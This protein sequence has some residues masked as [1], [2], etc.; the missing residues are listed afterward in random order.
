MVWNPTLA[1]RQLIALPAVRREPDVR[2][3]MFAAMAAYLILPVIVNPFWLSI[4]DQAGI[5]A[6]AAL[7]LNLLTGNA[8]Q[9]SLGH[10]F[11]M[12]IGAYAA[13]Y[14]GNDLHLPLIL[15]LP[16][17]ALAG[18][19]FGALVGPFALRLRGQYLVVVTLG[20]VMIGMHV[21]QNWAALTGGA[22][23]RAVALS[24]AIG[25]FDFAALTLPRIGTLTRDHSYYYLIWCLVAL[26]WLLV[27]NILDSRPGRAL[28]AVRDGEMTAEVIGVSVAG[29][30]IAAFVISSMLAAIG[31][32]MYVAYVRY[33]TPV[34]WNLLL[35]VQYL[36]IIAIGGVGSPL[37]AVLGALFVTS[38][39]QI[40]QFV[41]P[42][43][44]FVTTDPTA[45]GS[46]SVF[47]LNQILFGL[48]IVGFLMF[49]PAGLIGILTRITD[50]WSRSRFELADNI[51][52]GRET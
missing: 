23:G 8:G 22:P 6:I 12:G 13:A 42:L 17:A 50:H 52:S 28:M 27:R 1:R 38:V 15:W 11:F 25:P 41:S 32:A 20:L 31:G 44:P 2:G 43:L 7:G 39:P 21:F 34:E 33:C 30:K 9:V 5:V 18:G 35:G 36:A 26:A 40:V 47:S 51:I 48:L 16:A 45:Q 24:A 14:V 29:Y 49:E 37:G 10:P 46:I 3:A 4:L 19:V